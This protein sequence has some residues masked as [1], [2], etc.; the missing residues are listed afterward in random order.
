MTPAFAFRGRNG[1]IRRHVHLALAFALAIAAL[2]LVPGAPALG[3]TGPA[4]DIEKSTNGEDADSPPGPSV[5]VTSPVTWTYVVTN[6]GGVPL[7]DVVVSDNVINDSAIQF[8]GGDTNNDSLLDLT[9]TWTYQVSSISFWEIHLPT[10]AN[11]GTVTATYEGQQVSDSDDSHFSGQ[12]FCPLAV[13]AGATIVN[14][15]TVNGGFML[16]AAPTSPSSVGPIALDLPAGIYEVTLSSY[17]AHILKAPPQAQPQEQYRV[18]LSNGS[19]VVSSN[20]TPDLS[21]LSDLQSWVVND[22][23]VVGFDATQITAVHT[24]RPGQI[25]SLSALCVV[26]EPVSDLSIGVIKTPNRTAVREPGGTVTFTVDT[27]NTSDVPLSIDEITD[28]V[29]GDL[30]DVS[31]SGVSN[32]TCPALI[33]TTLA[34]GAETT[35]TFQAFISSS[36]ENTVTVEGSNQAGTP[37]TDSDNATVSIIPENPD[38]DL[39]K[40]GVLDNGSDG[41]DTAGDVITYTF[42]VTNTGDDPLTDV[43]VTDPL[44]GLSA[45]D[46]DTFDG[47]LASGESTTCTATYAVTQADVNSGSV[48]NLATATGTTPGNQQVIDTDPETVPLEQEP[49]I[50]IQKTPDG[51][52]VD[53]GADHTF[54]IVVTNI[55]NV[56]LTGVTVTDALVPA[57]DASLGTLAPGGVA[58]YDCVA[59]DVEDR[60]DNVAVVVGTA[61]D[62]S[63][64]TDQDTAVV[65]ILEVAGSGL[66]GDT[67]WQDTNKNGVQ[68]SG[69]PGIAGAVVRLTNVDTSATATDTTDSSGLYLFSALDPANYRVELVTSSVSGELTTPGSF[70]FFLSDGESRLD[71]DFGLAETLPVT[72]IDSDRLGLAAIILILLGVSTLLVTR[73]RKDSA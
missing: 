3:Q 52:E 67:V 72:G 8:V 43:T 26:F 41:V 51:A 58:T 16:G 66:I 61:P 62:E 18:D 22:A 53:V 44:P 73:R 37:V 54:T 45:I 65:T 63:E 68:D 29:F 30:G 17:D 13:P 47:S 46:C 28:T 70:Q 71:A 11:T 59:E 39:V 69:E 4:I 32:N 57:C 48:D 25:D 35:C 64:V 14:F 7:S 34:A 31:N 27:T 56:T 38:I 33:G 20:E 12:L 9:E 60:I 1:M 10:I 36:H 15:Y 24:G 19:S 40:T 2:V 21:E 50:D 55:G 23:L 6:P 5:P 42:D 49:E